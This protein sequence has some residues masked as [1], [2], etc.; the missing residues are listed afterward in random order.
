MIVLKL[1]LW[2]ATRVRIEGDKI[3]RRKQAYGETA[4]EFWKFVDDYSDSQRTTWLFAHNLGH[5]LT[6]L[7]FWEQL[8]N[9]TFTTKPLFRRKQVANKPAEPSWIGKLC[10]EALP[11]YL[12][13]RNRR[14]TY[15]FVDTCNY[16]PKALHDIGETI[17]VRKQRMPDESADNSIWRDYCEGDVRIVEYAVCNLIGQWRREDSGVFQLTAPSLAMTNFK[18]ICDV[19]TPDGKS[20]DMVCKPDAVEHDL[21][22]EAYFGGRIQCFFVGSVEGKVYHLDCNS[23]Y[24]YVMRENAY[25]R[26]FVSFKRNPTN[27]EVQRLSAIYGVVARVLIDSRHQTF[28]LRVQGRQYHCY[29]RYWASL[30]GP[31]LRRAFDTN[32]V[33]RVSLCQSYSTARLFQHW[34]DYWYQRKVAATLRGEAGRTER[35]FCKLILNSLSGKFAQHGR[36]WKDIPERIPRLRWGG[37]SEHSSANQRWEKWRGIGGNAQ[38][39]DDHKEPAHA[40]PLIS[41]CITSYARE[42]MR[43]VI[44]LCPENSVYYM[45][46]DSLLCDD[47]AYKALLDNGLLHNTSIGKFKLQGVYSKVEILGPNWYR[48]DDKE[49]ATGRVGKWLSGARGT[50]QIELWEQLPSIVSKGPVDETV[51]SEV[52]VP[53][54][55][56]DFRGL[57]DASGWWFPHCLMDDQDWRVGDSSQPAHREYSSDMLADR[58]QAPADASLPQR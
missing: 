37:W 16:W 57:I 58:I 30:C 27:D 47:K 31:E 26:R 55:T 34:V 11:T 56:P 10:L 46:T 29:G 22:R 28:P 38:R 24:P 32:S 25:P 45:A 8:D 39:L 6:Q 15:R 44:N 33:A 19:R 41:A 14:R 49:I 13:V 7:G 18:H 21:E 35:E 3:T 17:G 20:P 52:D 54:P 42:Y 4:A 36:H 9:G 1:R 23:L 40:F 43:Q 48:L 53:T 50:K 12:V 5:D 2:C 51:I